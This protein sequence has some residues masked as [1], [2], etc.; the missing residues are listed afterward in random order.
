MRVAQARPLFI[1]QEASWSEGTCFLEAFLG[2]TA[3]H[4]PCVL[5]GTKAPQGAKATSH[6]G[7]RDNRLSWPRVQMG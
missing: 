6:E 3:L 1:P 5:A 7:E 2:A 4:Y